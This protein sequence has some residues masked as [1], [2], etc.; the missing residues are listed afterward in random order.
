MGTAACCV[1]GIN[2]TALNHWDPYSC[3][4]CRNQAACPAARPAAPHPAWPHGPQFE[5]HHGARVGLYKAVRADKIALGS[6]LT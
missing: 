1:V 3:D 2:A 6:Q 5:P 4:L